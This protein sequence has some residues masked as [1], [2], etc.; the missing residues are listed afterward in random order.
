MAEPE[1]RVVRGNPT[2]LEEVA[3][4]EAILHLWRREQQEA[5]RAAGM[6][7][8]VLAARAEATG[9][10]APDFRAEPGAWR[11]GHRLSGLGLV[12][13]RRTGRGDSR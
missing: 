13:V 5:R 1:F 8:W 7:P 10:G 11:R 6:S 4:R 9:F 12:S 3:I 2:P